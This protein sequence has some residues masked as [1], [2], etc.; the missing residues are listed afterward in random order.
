M[1]Y[2]LGL[3]IFGAIDPDVQITIECSSIAFSGEQQSV[4]QFI[5]MLEE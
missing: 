1:E 3:Y 2:I 5:P 4:S